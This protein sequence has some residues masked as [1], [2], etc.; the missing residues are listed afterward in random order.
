MSC[1]LT[2]RDRRPSLKEGG[3]MGRPA[4][5]HAQRPLPLAPGDSVLTVR[6]VV[7]LELFSTA[8]SAVE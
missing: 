8:R 1:A 4:H 3:G 2:S 7:L 5:N 6:T